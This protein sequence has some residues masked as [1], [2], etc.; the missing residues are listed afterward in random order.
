[1]NGTVIGFSRSVATC[2][3]TATLTSLPVGPNP[4]PPPLA[5]VTVQHNGDGRILVRT[6]DPAGNATSYPFNLIVAC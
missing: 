4:D 6:W 2:V 1:M 3:A 5:H